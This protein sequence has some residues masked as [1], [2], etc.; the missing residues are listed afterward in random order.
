MKIK[1]IHYQTR[2][3]KDRYYYNRPDGID[4]YVLILAH[5]QAYF[6]SEGTKYLLKDHQMFIYDKFQPQLFYSAG[7]DFVHDW[8]HFDMTPEEA[9]QVRENGI[10]FGK[11]ITLQNAALFSDYIKMISRVHEQ[12]HGRSAAVVDGLMHCF[13]ESLAD[14]LEYDH[15]K[16]E[17]SDYPL[18]NTISE[19]RNRLRCYPYQSWN[20]ESAARSCNISKTWFQH[21]YRQFF[22]TTFQS[23]LSMFR[24]EYAKKMLLQSDDKIEYIA[25]NMCGYNNTVH[26]IR[27][28]KALTG[29][30]PSSYRKQYKQQ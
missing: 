3:S 10:P 8:F 14:E 29:F 27:Q 6:F 2:D 23:D 20:L 15:T 25:I 9:A 4:E 24:V 5:T 16:S 17:F 30:T 21:L 18:W 22:G 11:P 26:F 7:V 1:Y 28:F 19:F 12:N 13:F